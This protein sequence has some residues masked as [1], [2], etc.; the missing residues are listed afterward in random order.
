M[1]FP[2]FPSRSGPFLLREG[3]ADTPQL[4]RGD[5]RVLIQRSRPPSLARLQPGPMYLSTATSPRARWQLRQ[6]NLRSGTSLVGNVQGKESLFEVTRLP[7]RC[8]CSVFP[9]ESYGYPEGGGV[10]S[11]TTEPSLFFSSGES[12]AV[13]LSRMPSSCS[14]TVNT[15]RDSGHGPTPPFQSQRTFRPNAAMRRPLACNAPS[16]SH[17]GDGSSSEP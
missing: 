7:L 17:S 6:P 8:H 16:V 1:L 14:L 5:R 9:D 10:S 13:R 2:L 11:T 3:V 15:I 4:D 12:L